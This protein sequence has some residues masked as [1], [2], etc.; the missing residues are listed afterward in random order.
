LYSNLDFIN[1]CIFVSRAIYYPTKKN[2][3]FHLVPG[4]GIGV[5]FNK[6]KALFQRCQEKVEEKKKEELIPGVDF[7]EIEDEFERLHRE[8]MGEPEE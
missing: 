2:I 5:G 7:Q 6:G 4:A 3:I 1:L 8:M